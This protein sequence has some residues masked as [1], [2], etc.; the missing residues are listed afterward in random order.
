MTKLLYP[1]LAVI[2]VVSLIDPDRGEALATV[3]GVVA[4]LLISHNGGR[5]DE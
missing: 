5:R 2:V 3:L 4:M 1:L